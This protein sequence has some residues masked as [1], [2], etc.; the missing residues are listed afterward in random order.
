MMDRPAKAQETLRHITALGM[1][2]AIDDYG[3]GHSSLAYL[4]QLPVGT[5]KID[6]SFVL[7]VETNRGDA[8][9]VDSTIKLAH[10]L[11]LSV[12]AEGVETEGAL[13]VLEQLGCDLAQG[14]HIAR[15]MPADM[16]APWA[17]QHSALRAS[18]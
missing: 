14:F 7:N 9:I 6:K 2:V 1:S 15:P 5:L 13:R 16:V 17:A 18:T 4:R 12:V 10:S 8:A 11:G 3:T